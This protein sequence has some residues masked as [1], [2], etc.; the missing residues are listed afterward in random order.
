[1]RNRL[2]NS[3][4]SSAAAKLAA[5]VDPARR[6]H[7]HGRP[8]PPAAALRGGPD[9]WPRRRFREIDGAPELI[10]VPAPDALRAH[11]CCG[12]NTRYEHTAAAGR[13]RGRLR[14]RACQ[15]PAA[16]RRSHRWAARPVGRQHRRRGSNAR[17]AGLHAGAWPRRRPCPPG[18]GRRGDARRRL[19]RAG[20]RNRLGSHRSPRRALGARCA[21]G[22][23]HHGAR[24]WATLAG[25]PWVFDR[26]SAATC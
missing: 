18:A 8:G 4:V 20:R 9:L 14:R 6:S 3:A 17:S 11:C 13:R 23:H 1:M 12:P 7:R 2:T 22:W 5:R 21:R 15:R 19:E 24:P 26:Q 25:P 10:A 16:G